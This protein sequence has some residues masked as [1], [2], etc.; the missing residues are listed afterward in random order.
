MKIKPYT[1]TLK[2]HECQNPWWGFLEVHPILGS[3]QTSPSR[4]LTFMLFVLLL[5]HYLSSVCVCVLC[6]FIKGPVCTSWHKMQQIFFL[7][8][9]REYNISRPLAQEAFWT[10]LANPCSHAAVDNEAVSLLSLHLHLFLCSPSLLFIFLL[11]FF[12]LAS[13][14]LFFV[15]LMLWAPQSP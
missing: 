4:I 13:L 1:H 3:S 9:R 14:L 6:V 7:L 11:L 2:Q 5:G 10:W 15:C 12:C 8:E